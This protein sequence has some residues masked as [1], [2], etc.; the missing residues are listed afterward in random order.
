M[1]LL[2]PSPDN[3]GAP[4]LEEPSPP[5]EGP[6]PGRDRWRLGILRQVDFRRLWI[7]DTVSQFG[8]Q[9]SA[10]AVPYTAIVFLDASAAQVG[11]LATVEFLPF[12]LFTLPA[13]AWIDRLLRRP[14]LIGG[15]LGRAVVLSTVPV[16]FVFGVLTI[17]QLY[18]VG[19]LVGLLTVFFDGA[20]QS[21]L[22][23]IVA[24]DELIEGNAKLQIS[25]SSAQVAG[26]PLAGALVQ[27]VAAPVTI[28]IDAV[29]YL[30]SAFFVSRIQRQEAAPAA[31]ASGGSPVERLRAFGAEIGE[32]LRYVTGHRYLANIALCTGTANLFGNIMFT[33]L[34]LYEVRYLG[35]SPGVIGLIGFFGALG[36]LL[37]GFTATP[38]AARVGVGRIIVASIFIGGIAALLVP[39]APMSSLAPVFIAVSGAIGGWS[40]VVYN[41]NQVSLRQAITPNAMMGRM[42]A[43]MRFLVWGTIPIGSALGGILGSLIG[44]HETIWLG[45]I[46][47]CFVFLAVLLSPV[48]SLRRIEDAM[49]VAPEAAPAS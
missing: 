9:I 44:V 5:P 35:I 16:A 33:L 39:L 26:Q 19:F 43:T 42:N 47:G 2:S 27:L 25:A 1:T 23:A 4:D 34:L 36:A 45:A 3:A 48:R 12:L 21:Y 20:Y 15:D 30:W 28:F 41:V 40:S 49:T 37:G 13:G 22:P 38:L 14:I 46:M 18:V 7:A 31:R 10:F 32:G 6:P 29:S 17:W 8:T 11:A 24:D